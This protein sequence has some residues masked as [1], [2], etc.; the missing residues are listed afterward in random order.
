MSFW[1]MPILFCTAHG[2]LRKLELTDIRDKLAI[3][4]VH[5]H[6]QNRKII[7]QAA[8]KLMTVKVSR[9]PE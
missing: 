2:L 7:D 4:L 6:L 3:Y 9:A 5:S 8:Q 1:Q